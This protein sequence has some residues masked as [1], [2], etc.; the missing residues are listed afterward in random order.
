MFERMLGSRYPEHR[1]LIHALG[2]IERIS[3]AGY[4]SY[5]SSALHFSQWQ[6]NE[7]VARQRGYR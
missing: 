2:W 3:L 5:Q 7:Q 4:L 6:V 1:R